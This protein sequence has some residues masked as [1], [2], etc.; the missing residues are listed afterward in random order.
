M[1]EETRAFVAAHRMENVRDLALHAKR[2]ESVDMP[3][4]LDQ[5]AG[6]QTARTK[7][8]EWAACDGVIYPPHLSMEQC[9]S[10]ATARYKASVAERIIGAGAAEN[11]SMVDLTG[12]FGVDF[13][14]MARGFARA[15]YVERQANLCELAEHNMAALGLDH[16]NVV[17]DEAEHV[18]AS[19]PPATLVFLDPARRDA[20]GARTYAIADCTPDV[21]GL[22]DALLAKAPHV[23][24]KLSPMLDWHKTVEDFDGLVHEVHIVSAGDEC[25]ELLLVIGR[26]RVAAPRIFCVDDGRIVD[27]AIADDVP[28]SAGADGSDLA[29][30]RF[31]YEPNA[32]I[33]KA[34]CFGLIERRFSVRQIAPNSHLFVGV[35]PVRDF[36]GRSFVI[37]AVCTMNKRELRRALD[38]VAK[39]NIAVRNFPM[40]VAALR[41]KL[42]LKD[43]GGIY[44]F[45]TTSASGEHLLLRT[46][47]MPEAETEAE[48]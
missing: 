22:I 31:L 14:Y 35:S 42:K 16:V 6:W 29:S 47:K 33:M 38:G 3:L 44:L 11:G 46:G 27:Y 8:P 40:P 34:G 13:S 37:K 19:M 4:A 36:P 10:Q 41:R 25:K 21:L 12:G 45:A 48:A 39:A 23:M 26:E 20:H 2:S 5:I 28:A 24:V 9:S 7:L 18:I 43:G 1:N 30:A 17:N 32:S 15:T